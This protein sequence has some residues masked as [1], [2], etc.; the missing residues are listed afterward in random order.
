MLYEEEPPTIETTN[1]QHQTEENPTKQPDEE[2]AALK[3]TNRYFLYES[4]PVCG[5]RNKF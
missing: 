3:T 2:P 4:L 5:N 1:F